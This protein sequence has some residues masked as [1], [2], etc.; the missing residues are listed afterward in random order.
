MEFSSP[1]ARFLFVMA[2]FVI[3]VAGMRAAESILVPFLLSLFV[4]VI[5]TPPLLWLRSKG[6][7]N[8]LAMLMVISMIIVVGFLL[9]AIVGSSITEFS[10]DLP[11]YQARL[12]EI[13][14]TLITKLTKATLLI[15]LCILLPSIK[16]SLSPKSRVESVVVPQAT[17]RSVGASVNE[18]Y[19]LVPCPSIT[20]LEHKTICTSAPTA[21][22]HRQQPIN[23]RV[24]T[25]TGI[26]PVLR[27]LIS[28]DSVESFGS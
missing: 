24:V 21:L 5:C 23:T 16:I 14:A 13:T 28:P 3:V 20:A 11:E 1:I 9:G 4:A 10:Q 27:L 17:I 7:P 2:C 12:S 26:T 22:I 15:T 25:R 8:A 18:L 19:L 6:I